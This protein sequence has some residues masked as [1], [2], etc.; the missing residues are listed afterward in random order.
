MPV[1]FYTQFGWISVR[2]VHC[3]LYYIDSKEMGGHDRRIRDQNKVLLMASPVCTRSLGHDIPISTPA[4]SKSVVPYCS[5]SLTNARLSYPTDPAAAWTA[6]VVFI[7][8]PRAAARIGA[9][10]NFQT[11]DERLLGLREVT[12]FF[13]PAE[14][15]PELLATLTQGLEVQPC[16]GAPQVE[17]CDRWSTGRGHPVLT[18]RTNVSVPQLYGGSLLQA[19]TNRQPTF[20]GDGFVTGEYVLATKWYTLPM[21]SAAVM[22]RFDFFMKLDVDVCFHDQQQDPELAHMLAHRFRSSELTAHLVRSGAWFVHTRLQPDNPRCE[23]GLGSFMAEHVKEHP[24][25]ATPLALQWNSTAAVLPPVAYG[26]FVAGWLGFWQ[27][28]RILNFAERWYG[29]HSGWV[30][31]WTDQQFFMPALRVANVSEERIVSLSYL[32]YSFFEHTKESHFCDR[33]HVRRSYIASNSKHA[34]NT[35][36]V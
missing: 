30:H 7:S 31:R 17:G 1:T 4:S 25:A 10:G 22:R 2:T 35:S 6:I 32:R 26:N 14:E 19:R 5:S 18:C 15:P 36:A 21:L 3:T 23:K 16:V 8:N 28:D 24:C 29:Y 11:W 27:S 34:T 33:A 20:C 12:I 13:Y 9:S